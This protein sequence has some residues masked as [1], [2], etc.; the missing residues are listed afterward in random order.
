MELQGGQLV[1]EERVGEVVVDGLLKAEL[2][3]AAQSRGKLARAD[4]R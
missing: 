3:E 2:R 4:L 1:D